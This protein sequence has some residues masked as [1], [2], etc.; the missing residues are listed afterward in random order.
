MWNNPRIESIKN[1]LKYGWYNNV[2][3]PETIQEDID[4]IRLYRRGLPGGWVF[5]TILKLTKIKE[6]LLTRDK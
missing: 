4:F 3:E 5:F 6:K 1:G 2:T